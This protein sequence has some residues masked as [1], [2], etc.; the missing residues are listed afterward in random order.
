VTAGGLIDAGAAARTP[1]PAA[2][3]PRTV[4]ELLARAVRE[5]PEM[6]AIVADELGAG[7]TAVS[8]RELADAAANVAGGLAAL[9][10]GHGDRV[11]IL[12]T[13]NAAVEAHLTIHGAQRAG[14]IAV[15][16]NP[17]AAAG[18][19]L[20]CLEAAGCKVLVYEPSQAAKVAEIGDRIG[21]VAL[22][23]LDPAGEGTAWSEVADHAPI[24]QVE[25]DGADGAGW[26]FTSGTTGF[27]KIVAHTHATSVACGVQIAEGWDLRRGDVY[28]NCHPMFTAS[29]TNTDL[30][31]CLWGLATN[32]VEAKFD[33]VESV[34]RVNRLG[35]TSVMWMTPM[36]RLIFDADALPGLEPGQL[37][38][39][40]YG[41]QAMPEEFHLEVDD[42]LV[43]ERGLEAIHMIGLS[44]AGPGGILLDSEFHRER[45]GA[46]GNRGFSPEL[47]EFA[48]LD[49]AG[50]PVGPGE[51]GELCYRSPSIMQGY[52]GDEAA[53]A[54][55]LRGG[56][57]HSG[58]LCRYDDDG[59]VYFADRLKDVIRRGGVNIASAEVERVV[60][61]SPDVAEVAAVPHPHPV[62]GEVVRVVVVRRPGSEID[63]DAVIAHAASQLADFKVPRVVD[64][65]DELP[66]NDMGKVTKALLR[67]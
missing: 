47:T 12:L 25:I 64:F 24:D 22:V 9:G 13:N 61:E 30:L 15:P 16:I 62:L 18:E 32:V 63:A 55:A 50:E 59:F 54:E 46:V 57:L 41:G 5:A 56:W 40:M 27:P 10:I 35:A 23:A 60:G 17:R 58:D 11:G 67:E 1:L 7:E 37:R 66:R 42:V 3:E 53:S 45:P 39:V 8:H 48:L 28:V 2:I 29:G 43:R 26:V 65:V 52:V 20:W 31:S 33:A 14:A 44:E 6:T 36:L 38:R 21:E 34:E 19:L 4:P 51:G 49:V